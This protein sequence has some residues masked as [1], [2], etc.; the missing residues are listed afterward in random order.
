MG[1]APG[2]GWRRRRREA[3]E[4][5]PRMDRSR[6]G[7]VGKSGFSTKNQLFPVSPRLRGGLEPVRMRWNDVLLIFTIKQYIFE[8]AGGLAAACGLSAD[9]R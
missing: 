9:Y 8:N 3:D 1:G 7:G 5:E 6:S 2:R 4:L